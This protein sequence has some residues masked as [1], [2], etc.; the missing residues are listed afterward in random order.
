[1]PSLEQELKEGF[2][3]I[4]STFESFKKDNDKEI[5]D[6]K[7]KGNA[8]GD[9]KERIDKQQKALDDM[10]AKQE[11]IQTALRRAGTSEEGGKK[12]ETENDKKAAEIMAKY[13]R[14][15]ERR[16]TEEEQKFFSEHMQR[17]GLTVSNDTEGGYLVRPEV[18]SMITKKLFESSPIRQ[19]AGIETISTDR[20]EEPADFDEP[21]AEWAGE[22]QTVSET[23][24]NNL[25]MLVIPTHEMRAKPKASQ[26]ILEDS[27]IDIEAWHAAKVVEKF[28]RLEATAFVSGNGAKRPKGF[29][30]YDHGT[31]YNQVEQLASASSGAIAA[32]DLIGLQHKLFEG[33]QM[34]ARWFMHRST[35]STIRKL[36]DGQGRYLWSMDGN[37]QDGYQQSLLGRPLHWASDMAEVAADALAV[38]YG[39]FKQGYLIVDRVGISVLRDPYSAKPFV[40]F[41]TR[42]RVG[43]GVRNFQAIKLLKLGTVS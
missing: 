33:Y 5:A 43:G 7:A 18:S 31:G 42:K 19:H 35:A 2:D 10:L 27:Y 25:S 26:Q 23:D 3:Q 30:S 20:F 14:K 22:Q 9:L 32:D 38:A 36:K 21:D 34:N 8:A 6:L 28:A 37:L 11:E 4:K 41:Y 12:E 40:E 29:T 17:K 13:L 39:D 15:G 24:E 1:M 16:V